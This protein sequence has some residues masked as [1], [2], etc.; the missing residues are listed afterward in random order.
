[1]FWMAFIHIIVCGALKQHAKVYL[2]F[3]ENVF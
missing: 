2:C 3:W 1:L